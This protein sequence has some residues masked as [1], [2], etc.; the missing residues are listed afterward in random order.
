MPV[1]GVTGGA[2]CGKTSFVGALLPLLPGARAFSADAAVNQ[3]AENDPLVRS[4]LAALLGDGAFTSEGRYNRPLVR[5]RVFSE[6]VLR[7]GVDAIF[8]PRV[9]ALWTT[10]AE[11]ARHSNQ[12]LLAEIPLLYETGADVLCDRV[13]TVACSP[14]VQWHRLTVLRGL[15]ETIASQ[16][17]VAQMRLEEKSNRADHLIWND[18]PF[19]CLQRQ[20]G[21]CAAWLHRSGGRS[22]PGY[23]HPA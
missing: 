9:R 21:L 3:L 2:A 20:A 11:K 7:A 17:R 16:I 19:P 10:L 5:E 4:E 14:Q 13:A 1:L 23:Q 15:T 22:D 6:P 8:H 12:W 18:F